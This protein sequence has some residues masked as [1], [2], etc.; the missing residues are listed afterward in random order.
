MSND[1]YLLAIN[2]GFDPAEI[3]IMVLRK[4]DTFLFA[5]QNGSIINIDRVHTDSI[6]ASGSP[7]VQNLCRYIFRTQLS[8]IMIC[9]DQFVHV[10][11]FL[12]I[13]FQTCDYCDRMNTAIRGLLLANQKYRKQNP[14]VSASL[15]RKMKYIWLFRFIWL[16]LWFH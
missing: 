2:E 8:V 5:I 7:F 9:F 4:R 1:E 14:G 6:F 15:N 12:Y 10:N 11:D 13:N 3:I 16:L